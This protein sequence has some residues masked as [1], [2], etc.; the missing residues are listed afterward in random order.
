VRNIFGSTLLNGATGYGG[1]LLVYTLPEEFQ[2]GLPSGE[3]HKNS[4]PGDRRGSGKNEQAGLL[5]LPLGDP[6]AYIVTLS[7]V[8]L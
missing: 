2:K 5:Q 1:G 8:V 3:R 7:Y 4:D 6:Y